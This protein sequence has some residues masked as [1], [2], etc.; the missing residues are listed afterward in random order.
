MQFIIEPGGTLRCIYGEEIDLPTLGSVTIVR[1]SQVE[2]DR[3]GRWWAD[4][5]PI[6]GPILGPFC[7]RSEALT[8]E[9][10]WLET[11]WLGR[12]ARP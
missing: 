4:L 3:Q 10:A 2:P 1:A 6:D 5:S 11:N 9:H 12:A 8:A 7:T